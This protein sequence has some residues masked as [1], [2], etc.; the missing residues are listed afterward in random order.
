VAEEVSLSFGGLRV[1]D[2]V[3]LRVGE[4]EIVGLM[5]GNGAGKTTL[6]DCVSGHLRPEG[7]AIA[8]FG[9]AAT[10]LPADARPFLDVARSFQDCH[11]YPGL[12]VLE[13]VMVALDR[14][15]HTGALG[16]FAGAPWMRFAERRKRAAAVTLLERVGL[17]DRATTL[18]GELSTG[19]RRLCELATVFAA[20]PRLVLL[21][22]PTAGIAQRE[23][24]AFVPLLRALRDELGCAVLIVEHDVPLLLSL[25]DRLYAMESGTVIAEGPPQQ[26]RDDPRVVASYLGTDAA[27]IERSGG[28]G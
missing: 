17:D 22:E 24:E 20:R 4:G 19:V 1:L 25:C 13:T 16:A 11:L 26:V 10:G 14:D 2:G 7:G 21:D 9:R 3:S 12:T 6:L 18:V 8:L 28:G 15:D 27:A 5:G 23:V